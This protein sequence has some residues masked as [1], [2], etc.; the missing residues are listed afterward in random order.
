MVSPALCTDTQH[1]E[2]VPNQDN[3]EN[4]KKPITM[5]SSL[6]CGQCRLHVTILTLVALCSA[7]AA[8]VAYYRFEEGPANAAATAPNSILDSVGA[9]HG[10]PAGSPVYRTNVPVATL[11]QTG[12]AN[13]F[14]LQFSGG[15]SIRFEAPFLM[16]SNTDA[17]IE[18][19]LK[20]PN[21]HPQ[22]MLWTRRD[23]TDANRFNMEFWQGRLYLDYRE[24]GTAAHYVGGGGVG[25]PYDTWCHVAVTRKV[26]TNGTHTYRM[27]LDGAQQSEVVDTP[28]LPTDT[29]WTLSS[30]EPFT[31]Y[32]DEVRLSN[33]ALE[34]WQFLNGGGH[35]PADFTDDF[36][37]GVNTNLWRAE[38]NDP[39]YALDAS[40]GEIRFSRPAGV[41]YSLRSIWLAFNRQVR[42][43][44]DAS[45]D[46]R[47]ASINR[48]DGS[49]GNQ[50]QLYAVFGGQVIVVVRSDEA[51]SG[52]NAHV[53]RDPPG[54]WTGT[55]ATTATNG[56]FRITRVGTTVTAYF[57]Q[58][59]LHTGSY[60]TNP[61]TDLVF[62]LQ[63][64]GTRDALSVVFDNFRLKADRIVPAPVQ[65]Q[66]LG[67]AGNQ[68]RMRLPNPTPGAWHFIEHTPTLPAA[69]GWNVRERLTG[70]A[71]PMEWSDPSSGGLPAGFYRVRSE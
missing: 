30:R 45:V 40:Q 21:Q 8:T 3:P 55:I 68:F 48:V 64:N 51:G 19:Y 56:T 24:P 59:V 25:Y 6:A 62:D 61:V 20:A 38:S 7:H 23:G 35:A 16:N 67:P 39:L 42:G 71:F 54:A 65:M 57:N 50:V 58:T 28:V 46:F 10:S 13:R 36:S 60:N 44:F 69:S 34:P 37:A 63:N 12:A 47:N 29:V 70:G 31:G 17:T 41:S 11:P 15:Q 14:C 33:A 22:S 66:P 4:P 52:H 27:F 5:M 53:W 32:L 18:F 26:N 1:P 43:D 2:P 49:P 9:V